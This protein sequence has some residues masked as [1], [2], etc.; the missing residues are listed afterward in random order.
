MPGRL[1]NCV[2]KLHE[3]IRF[4]AKVMDC[5]YAGLSERTG[6]EDEITGVASCYR[7]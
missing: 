2:S 6:G 5:E 3:E 7:W 1:S 4:Y